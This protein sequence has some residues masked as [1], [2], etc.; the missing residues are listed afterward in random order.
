MASER[1]VWLMGVQYA[2]NVKLAGAQRAV[3]NFAP[4]QQHQGRPFVRL[5][6]CAG[7]I[8]PGHAAAL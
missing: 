1:G 2:V 5:S 4:V 7:R 3:G 6:A 8:K